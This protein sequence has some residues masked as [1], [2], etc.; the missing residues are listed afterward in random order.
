[1]PSST[2]SPASTSSPVSS[3]SATAT[4]TRGM[5]I[6]KSATYFRILARP[7]SGLDDA[8]RRRVDLRLEC[9]GGRVGNEPGRYAFDRGGE[10]A[11]Q[12]G[13]QDGRDLGAGAG[14]LDGVVHDHGSPCAADGFDDGV[15][16]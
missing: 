12:F 1:M 11:E 7:L 5:R 2:C 3:A 16:V 8:R 6:T 14:E 4:E 9:R 15:D 10:F 13:V